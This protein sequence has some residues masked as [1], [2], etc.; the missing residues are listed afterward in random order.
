MSNFLEFAFKGPIKAAADRWDIFLSYRSVSLPW[1]LAL[2]DVLRHLDYQVFMDQYVLTTSGSLED[3]K[4]GFRY[5]VV[6][7]DGADLPLFARQKLW[8]DF[9]A[10]REGP[11]GSNLLRLLCG[12]QGKPQ[13]PDAVILAAK[14]DDAMR[15]TF[16]R[17]LAL[18][19]IG[20]AKGLVE[21]SA[22]TGD[23]WHNS[24]I[25]G[26]KVAEALIAIGKNDEALSVIDKLKEQFPRSIRP[27]QLRG[28]ALARKG[29]W[30]EAQLTLLELYHLGERDPETLG[31]LART[32][33]DHY[34]HSGDLLNLRKA[35]DV[36]AEAFKSTPND[37]YTGIN[38]ASNSVLLG[39]IE[40]APQYAETVE[41]LVGTVAKTG[42]YWATATVAEVQ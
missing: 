19:E 40:A 26:C 8:I 11:S 29:E 41:K 34:A 28:L 14:M 38:A 24:S 22:G 32:W 37:F 25:L 35:R 30:Q 23:E 21:T 33:R 20:D 31:I 10:F 1:V 4:P 27:L 2:Y 3:S 16:A 12:L 9:S 17:I 13:P 7:L 36:Y 5:V 42:D 15:K 6:N 18:K 39:E